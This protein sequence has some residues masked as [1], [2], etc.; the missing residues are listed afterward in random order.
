MC[1]SCKPSLKCRCFLQCAPSLADLLSERRE[2]SLG[3]LMILYNR[4]KRKKNVRCDVCGVC[5]SVG[6]SGRHTSDP[7]RDHVRHAGRSNS[8]GNPGNNTLHIL[9]E[10]RY[11]SIPVST[12]RTVMCIQIHAVPFSYLRPRAASTGR[13]RSAAC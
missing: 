4:K 1:G 12:K 2:D 10:K 9:C 6:R 7:L 5:L 8:S 11:D 13:T 3:S